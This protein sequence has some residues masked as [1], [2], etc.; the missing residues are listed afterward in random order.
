MKFPV[1]RF[2]RAV[3]IGGL[4][5]SG[6]LP[7]Q[8]AGSRSMSLA[9]AL[10]IAA[11]KSEALD[12]ARA[13]VQRARGQQLQARSQYLPQLSGT[14]QYTR[15]LASQF[16]VFQESS[17]TP[18]PGTPPVPPNDTVSFF[19]PCSRYLAAAGAT[20]EERLRGLDLFARCSSGGG[21]IDFSR[22]GFGAKNQYQFG[23]SGSVN[24][25][26]GGRV[27]AQSRAANAGHRTA[28]IEVAAQRAQLTLDVTQAYYDAA[29]ADRLVAIADSTLSWTERALQQTRL[30]RQVGNTSEFELLRAQV[31][32]DNQVPA[33]LQQRT[34]RRLAYL[35]LKQMLDLP[36]NDSLRLT[37]QIDDSDA[38]V[39]AVANE[40]SAAQAVSAEDTTA[41]ARSTVRQLAEAV[42]AQEAQVKIARAERIPAIQITS[43]Y[44][45]VGF[46]SNAIPSWGNFL[47]NWTVGIGASVPL[48]TGGRIKGDE[49]VAAAGLAE[50][51]ARLQQTREAA[52]IDAQL[53]L[54]Q[55]EEAE[56]TLAASLGTAE[57]AS[58]AFSIADVRYREGISTQLELSESRMQFQ[59]A[60]A[61]RAQAARDVKVARIRLALLSD[62][63]LTPGN[64]AVTGGAGRGAPAQLP[65]GGAI[66]PGGAGGA[67]RQQP[68]A[69]RSASASI[70]PGSGQ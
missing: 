30:A 23:L 40:R 63:P 16:S 20:Q 50:A 57:Q 37:D 21:S 7:A 1:D 33:L 42:T 22:A 29:L 13:G 49:L 48:F 64:A 11:A 17:P 65:G 52:A 9:D 46:A 61:N 3:L 12:I 70:S 60:L 41:A 38:G 4:L 32:R 28:E 58:R 56:A 19:Q 39:R 45:R 18:P 8:T 25:Y 15:T 14:A 47:N 2:T 36:P 10:T 35:R 55:V 53:A 44:G 24:V 5:L 31:S 66:A 69:P 62:L 68:Q 59:Q 26:T 54:A 43:Q 67:G 34:N 6:R 51:K 27:A